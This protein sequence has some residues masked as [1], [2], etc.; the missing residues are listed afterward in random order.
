MISNKQIIFFVLVFVLFFV[1]VKC[2]LACSS[3]LKLSPNI[4][5]LLSA[6]IYTLLL[7]FLYNIT[8]ISECKDEFQFEVNPVKKC[9]GGPYMYSSNPQLK[10][11][12]DKVTPEQKEQTC[13]GYGFH[14]RPAHFDHIVKSDKM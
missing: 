5:L 11:F 2:S 10:A 4:S 12:C 8:N 3:Q 13:C 6:L 9:C 1:L 14:G 7:A